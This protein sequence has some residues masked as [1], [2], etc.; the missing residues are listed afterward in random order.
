M[1]RPVQSARP[2][3]GG[4]CFCAG[5][6]PRA[7]NNDPDIYLIASEPRGPDQP[8][9]HTRYGAFAGMELVTLVRAS[10]PSFTAMPACGS[11]VC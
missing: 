9:D 5:Q 10:Y 3:S 11:P 8:A 1:I 6:G 4:H 2:R 7:V